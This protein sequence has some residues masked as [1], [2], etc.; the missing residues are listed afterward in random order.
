[1]RAV[2]IRPSVRA[3][4]PRLLEIWRGAVDATHGFLRPEDR[5]ELDGQVATYVAAAEFWVAEDATGHPVG[6]LGMT[7]TAGGAQID[8]LFVD[9]ALHGRGY[10][11]ALLAHALA[12]ASAAT[13]D[14]NEQVPDTVAFYER[15]GFVRTGRSPIDDSGRPYPLVHFRHGG[16]TSE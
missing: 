12:I 4:A 11:S 7:S 10:G 3:D 13:V 15:R 16:A 8:S 2:R 6:F 5:A 1:M 9:P 14:A